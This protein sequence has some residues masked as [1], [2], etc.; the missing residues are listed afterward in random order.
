M[1]LYGE[2]FLRKP[3][4]TDIEKLYA[5]HYKKHGFPRMIENIDC[6]DWPWANCLHVLKAQFYRGDHGPGPFILLEA[7]ASQDLWI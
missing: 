5:H 1:E 6:T 2:E 4:V 7:I 3:T